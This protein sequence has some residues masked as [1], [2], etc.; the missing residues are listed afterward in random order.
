M[1]LKRFH[2]FIQKGHQKSDVKCKVKKNGGVI[3]RKE[4]KKILPEMA[5]DAKEMKD[6]RDKL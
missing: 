6:E 1:H 4:K 3:L 5:T 2:N